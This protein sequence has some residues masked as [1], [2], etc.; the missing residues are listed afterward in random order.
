MLKILYKRYYRE[1]YILYLLCFVLFEYLLRDLWVTGRP[2]FVIPFL[3]TVLFG[4]FAII[5]PCEFPKSY[6]DSYGKKECKN[7]CIIVKG[8][9][10]TWESKCDHCLYCPHSVHKYQHKVFKHMRIFKNKFL[11][12]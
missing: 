11:G 1:V 2:L 4:T 8:Y 10:Y 5:I 9:F 7:K 6:R 12:W 3:V